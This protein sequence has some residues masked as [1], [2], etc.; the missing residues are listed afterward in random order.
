[1][2]C[3]PETIGLEPDLDSNIERLPQ[4]IISGEDT[5]A[6]HHIPVSSYELD[7]MDV[8]IKELDL[9]DPNMG[10]DIKC[11]VDRLSEEDS[12]TTLFE[13]IF[14]IKSFTSLFGV[15]SYQNFIESIGKLEVEEDRQMF[16]ENGWKKRIFNDTKRLLRK[17]FRSVY[18]SQDDTNDGRSSRNRQS[19]IN[20]LKNLIPDLYL[21]MSGVGFL[22]RLR[23]VDAK[24]FDEDGKPCVNEFQK[25]FEDD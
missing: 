9:E 21:N 2:M 23:I 17:Q 22:Q 5:V 12:F 25:L 6:L 18:N 8:E 10:E 7:V 20:F 15:Y 4:S 24:P 14:K 11:Y 16:I 3:L 19:N 13:K 1:M